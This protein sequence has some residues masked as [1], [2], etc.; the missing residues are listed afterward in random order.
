[1]TRVRVNSAF[2]VALLLFGGATAGCSGPR[3]GSSLHA[4]TSQVSACAAALPV[5]RSAVS[6]RGLL[7]SI[8]PLRR[9]QADRIVR[10]LTRL[11]SPSSPTSTTSRGQGLALNGVACVLV[12]RGPYKPG[13]VRG[14]NLARGRY[15]LLIVRVRHPQVLSAFVLDHLP[16]GL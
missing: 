3:G 9:G 8:H 5:A 15:A 11:P 14:T 13:E 10:A 1:M 16:S 4:I 6:G 7:V 12:Y 2:V